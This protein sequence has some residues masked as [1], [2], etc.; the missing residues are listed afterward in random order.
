MQNATWHDAAAR[1]A[2]GTVSLGHARRTDAKRGTLHR[3]H[4]LMPL[5]S[6]GLCPGPMI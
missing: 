6:T 2:K 1:F 4:G 3:E 5:N